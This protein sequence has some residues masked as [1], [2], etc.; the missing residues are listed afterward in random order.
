M[1]SN[2]LQSTLDIK[3][4]II[5]APMFLVSKTK[6]L[7]AAAEAGITG[8]VPALNYRSD[9]DFRLALDELKKNCKGA[10]GIN[11]ITNR[12]NYRY[13]EQLKTCL[14]YKVDY[15]IT[16]LGSPQEV[17][18]KCKPAGIKVFCDVIDLHYAERVVKME[19][20][21]LIA[22]SAEAGGHCGTISYKEFIPMLNKEFNL[23]VISA[24]G[25]G[26]KAGMDEKLSI[27]A[28]GVSV[29]SPFIAT[30]E[31]GVGD[32]YKNACV[33]Y[34][35]KD[36]IKTT[37]LSGTPCTVINTPY[38]QEIGTEQNWIEK[39][40]GRYKWLKKYAKILTY[41]KGMKSLETAAFSATYKTIWCAGPSIEF[42]KKV[43]SV[44][45]VVG[46]LTV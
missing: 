46:E 16:S 7:I 28:C 13:K 31:S 14:E 24:G 32:E 39:L 27:G 30:N 6:M 25:V 1:H 10:F 34:G 12:S 21:A 43:R 20:D 29:G 33:Q 26:N 22:V 45:E 15:I 41:W 44:K 3:H 35:A 9:K 8:C 37:K 4:P 19:C 18:E 17:I 40:L 23:P 2:Y 11:L 38:L 36:I 5:M 42:T